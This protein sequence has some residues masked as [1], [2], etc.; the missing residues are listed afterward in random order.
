MPRPLAGYPDPDLSTGYAILKSQELL[1]A[2]ELDP[3]FDDPAVRTRIGEV[4]A[5]AMARRFSKR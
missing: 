2:Y 5:N 4:I 1:P 3:T